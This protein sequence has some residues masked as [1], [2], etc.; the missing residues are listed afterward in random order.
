[1]FKYLI[2]LGVGWPWAEVTGSLKEHGRDSF[3]T[4]PTEKWLFFY[5]HAPKTAE[6][7]RWYGLAVVFLH[8]NLC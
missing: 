1:M 4:L 8:D 3:L 6:G 7:K 2:P 5:F